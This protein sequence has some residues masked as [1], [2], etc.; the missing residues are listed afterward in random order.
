M[1]G[2]LVGTLN[3][4]SLWWCILVTLNYGYTK[5]INTDL[6]RLKYF[7]RILSKTAV[8]LLSQDFPKE[9]IDPGAIWLEPWYFVVD[10]GR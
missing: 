9:N 4:Q 2:D 7:Y 6:C 8:Q 1:V 10:G 5:R 3:I